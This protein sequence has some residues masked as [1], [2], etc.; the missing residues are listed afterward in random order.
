MC[1]VTRQYDDVTKLDNLGAGNYANVITNVMMER[2]A[3]VNGPTEGKILRPSDG[4]EPATVAFVQCAGSRDEN[5]LPY[6]SDVC[7]MGSL[8]QARYVREK[9]ADA[10]ISIFYIDVR[11]IGRFEHF[12]YE[13][14]EDE[15][16]SFIK[17]KVAKITEDAATKNPTVEAEDVLGGGKISEQFD[18]VVL[19]TGVVPSTAYSPIPVVSLVKDD[20]GFLTDSPNGGGIF[21]AGCVKRPLDVSRSVKDS[22][23]AVMKA[24]QIVR[25]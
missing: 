3:A 15:N 22:S 14:L 24:I 19:A 9:A 5:H 11:T 4:K 12:Y 16:I 7:C 6:C 17:G 10:K 18:L 13:L 25:R 1:A 20:N 23:A 2:M 8:K 21:A